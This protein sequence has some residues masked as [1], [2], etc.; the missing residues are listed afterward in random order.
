MLVF[1]PYG[2]TTCALHCSGATLPVDGERDAA[3]GLAMLW[4][5]EYRP[6]MACTPGL[7]PDLACEA[8]DVEGAVAVAML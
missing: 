6:C 5:R 2:P 7:N 4:P 1:E 3:D 8:G